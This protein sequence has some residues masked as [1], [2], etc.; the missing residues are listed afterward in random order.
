M[1]TIKRFSS[2]LS[3]QIK[4]LKGKVSINDHQRNE[5]DYR[6]DRELLSQL[7]E[8]ALPGEVLFDSNGLFSAFILRVEDSTI[9]ILLEHFNVED[10]YQASSV[11]I[12][13]AAQCRE[14]DPTSITYSASQI[15]IIRCSIRMIASHD[16]TRLFHHI[17]S[18]FSRISSSGNNETSSSFSM[19]SEPFLRR[20]LRTL[21]VLSAADVQ[22]TNLILRDDVFTST[23][24][25]N[26][27]RD[28]SV[29]SLQYAVDVSNAGSDQLHGRYLLMDDNLNADDDDDFSNI[30]RLNPVYSNQNGYLITRKQRR[31]SL[32]SSQCLGEQGVHTNELAKIAPMNIRSSKTKTHVDFIIYQWLF[33]NPS[34]SSTYYSHVTVDPSVLPP[35]LGWD[36]SGHLSQG[37]LPGPK[38]TVMLLDGGLNENIIKDGDNTSKEG[39]LI[40]GAGIKGDFRNI[41]YIAKMD[42]FSA[43]TSLCPSVHANHCR[44]RKRTV[45]PRVVLFDNSKAKKIDDLDNDIETKGKK[46][47]TE[48]RVGGLGLPDP[49]VIGN[50]S[51]DDSDVSSLKDYVAIGISQSDIISKDINAS[52]I[53]NV[54]CL[55]SSEDKRLQLSEERQ[56]P[57]RIALLERIKFAEIFHM[58][59]ATTIAAKL[60]RLNT[61]SDD[62]DLLSE[63]SY[64]DRDE[65][66]K[67]VGVIAEAF[68]AQWSLPQ[69]IKRTIDANNIKRQWNIGNPSRG[70]HANDSN[71]DSLSS[72]CKS[73]W[74]IRSRD[75]DDVSQDSDYRSKKSSVT[76]KNTSISQRGG[77][78]ETFDTQHL[79]DHLD[80]Q[81]CCSPCPYYEVS[82]LGLDLMIDGRADLS[83]KNIG[84][85]TNDGINPSMNFAS[86]RTMGNDKAYYVIR[87]SLRK[88]NFTDSYGVE[89]KGDSAIVVDSS[90]GRLSH[91]VFTIRR[92]L[93][94]LSAFHVQ[95]STLLLSYQNDNISEFTHLFPFPFDP[96]LIGS[97]EERLINLM[98]MRGRGFYKKDEVQHAFAY[99]KSMNSQGSKD[100]GRESLDSPLYIEGLDIAVHEVEDY[101]KRVFTLV[102]MIDENPLLH[103]QDKPQDLQGA[104]IDFRKQELTDVIVKR[105]RAEQCCDSHIFLSELG[106][107]IGTLFTSPESKVVDTTNSISFL[108]RDK[109]P[110]WQ[111]FV[112]GG[113]DM[114]KA[115]MGHSDNASALRSD[116]YLLKLQRGRC[117]GC[118]EPISMRWGFLGPDRNYRSCKYYDGLFCLKWCHSNE[119]R[120]IPRQILQNW[121]FKL[122]GVSRQAAQYLD[123]VWNKPVIPLQTVSPFLYERVL[124][125]RLV[126]KMRKRTIDMIHYHLRS[127]RL[128]VAEEWTSKVKV[129]IAIYGTE[130]AHLCLSDDLYSLSDLSEV[131]S[132]KL[133]AS[134]ERFIDMLRERDRALTLH[135]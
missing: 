42:S 97:V 20:Q 44:V 76:T 53:I 27:K 115:F 125:L 121:D 99:S 87:I 101:L 30:K 65:M 16:P 72:S 92:D 109:M 58:E 9:R 21:S 95:L 33:T 79:Y 48:T 131:H 134:L 112:F 94:F 52:K 127:D 49:T 70:V 114:H 78:K 50:N 13:R 74:N 11:F 15:G 3:N 126:K 119:R 47:I 133:L 51:I 96:F 31:I 12:A 46:T 56:S 129:A 41:T 83:S 40:T 73:Q 43:V 28:A 26:I 62:N 1:K 128:A 89:K 120:Q 6:D 86:E 110:C 57:S 25:S 91:Q 98:V 106:R 75:K 60:T 64:Y 82:V 124:E 8:D 61:I 17:D 135:N 32:S 113:V 45:E 104:L 23:L 132:G 117:I 55:L 63:H 103:K 85:G 39:D 54:H 88:N 116:E 107:L 100:W 90:D 102:E 77:N 122:H 68:E 24:S 118:D 34:I 19:L 69:L 36:Q 29:S 22:I 14:F 59:I 4:E 38:L 18:I 80:F 7:L 5:A 108:T 105:V 93:N 81:R 123:V 35:T 37:K 67:E 10:L 84:N 2:S 71:Q 130:K 111:P 66:E